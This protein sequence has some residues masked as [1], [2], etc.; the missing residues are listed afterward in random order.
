MPR[1]HGGVP[2]HRRHVWRTQLFWLHQGRY[3]A[4]QG[5]ITKQGDPDPLSSH[6]QREG[7]GT[8]P[9][10]A[11]GANRF[12]FK[13]KDWKIA[14]ISR[15]PPAGNTH[16]GTRNYGRLPCFSRWSKRRWDT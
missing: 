12:G 10:M 14:L 3:S 2:D 15:R 6:V 16:R 1:R 5:E 11:V 13:V 7:W 8:S 9:P 4:I